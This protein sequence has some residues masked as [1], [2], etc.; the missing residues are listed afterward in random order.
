MSGR[1]HLRIVTPDAIVVD[2]ADVVALRARDESGSFGILPGHT[3]L[4]TVVPASVL[5]WRDEHGKGSFCAVRSGVLSV[6]GGREMAVA[7]REALP[8]GKLE[9]LEG[10]ILTVQAGAEEAGRITR[11]GQMR[12]HAQAVRLLMHYLAPRRQG[13]NWNSFDEEGAR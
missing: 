9:S 10:E 11:V 1:L 5:S 12:L 8:G 6:S 7:C 3:D 2:A 4:L 13:S